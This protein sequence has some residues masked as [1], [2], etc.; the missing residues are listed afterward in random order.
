MLL[1]ALPVFVAAT[2]GEAQS[3]GDRA[4]TEARRVADM[5]EYY[6][7]F[8]RRGPA[9]TAEVTP[10]SRRLSEA[11]MANIDRLIQSG[12][13]V[14][15]GPF[16]RQSGEQALAGLFILRTGS[17]EEARK[18]VESDPAVVAGRFVYEIVP[19]FGPKT[20]GY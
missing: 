19:W 20:L 13:M 16:S 11:H 9:W 5:V 15:A 2:I 6:F 8:L 1:I 4:P 17:I 10:E 12:E 3:Q 7:V 18:I 14:V